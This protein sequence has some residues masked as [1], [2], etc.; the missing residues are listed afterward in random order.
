MSKSEEKPHSLV[1]VEDIAGLEKPACALI[2]VCSDAV[3]GLAYS[4]QTKR[5]AKADAEAK[6]ITAKAD[7]EVAIIE[8]L[9]DEEKRDIVLRAEKRRQ[10]EEIIE[11]ENMESIV[12]KAI[13]Y[14]QENANPENMDNSWVMNFFKK[15]RIESDNKMQELWA[16]VLSGE[17]NSPGKYSKRTVNLLEEIDKRDAELFSTLCRF[18]FGFPAEEQIPLVF[19]NKNDIY[20]KESIN[21]TSLLHLSNIGLIDFSGN[22]GYAIT[23]ST[24]V[25][26]PL[27]YS[28][29]YGNQQQCLLF[30][31]KEQDN[32]LSTGE[33]KL[34]KIGQELFSLCERE[35][36]PGFLE[37][38]QEQWKEY[39]LTSEELANFPNLLS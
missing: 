13:P 37:Y 1:N 16:K 19:D 17:A 20:N 14:L 5:K 38:V 12:G 27:F 25:L 26:L 32:V 15:S 34:T 7:K 9:S 33:V 11:Q 30:L 18:C 39:Q 8:A 6:I 35:A 23:Y 24:K 2:K 22:S 10:R 21:F 31:R 29:S 28:D 3:G 4:W 36:V